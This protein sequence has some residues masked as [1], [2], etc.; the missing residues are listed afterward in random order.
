M[1]IKSILE[2]NKK[3]VKN[4]LLK[5]RQY[6][7]LELP[8]YIDFDGVLNVCQERLGTKTLGEVVDFEKLDG[9]CLR[10]NHNI[11]I[12]KGN[13]RGTRNITLTNPVLYNLL[14]NAIVDNWELL[15]E[16]FAKGQN[17]GVEVSS[18]PVVPENKEKFHNSTAILNW[19][20]LMEQGSLRRSLKYKRMM[21]TD[22][23]HCYENISLEC[24]KNALL[25]VGVVDP[26]KTRKIMARDIENVLGTIEMCNGS[27]GLPQ[28]SVVYDL[29]AELV[30]MNVDAHIV[31][32]LEKL[33]LADKCE[34]LRY[35]DDYRVFSNSMDALYEVRGVL[36]RVLATFGMEL[37]I[38]KTYI[39]EDIVSDALKKDKVYDIENTPIYNGKDWAFKGLT[40]HLYYIKSFGDKFPDSGQLKRLL[41][42]FDDRLTNYNPAMDLGDIK[43]YAGPSI[44]EDVEPMIAIAVHILEQNPTCIPQLSRIIGRLSSLQC[45]DKQLKTNINVCQLLIE[46]ENSNY[47]QV[48]LQKLT[49]HPE[50]KDKVHYDEPLCSCIDNKENVIWDYSFLRKDLCEVQDVD[51]EIVDAEILNEEP[52]IPNEVLLTLG[53]E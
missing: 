4:F 53:Y 14:V 46:A 12:P 21:V 25:H 18:L 38:Q 8:D 43:I 29:L 30:L 11:S 42:E 16:S 23:S 17:E 9:E 2:L 47:A 1:K 44:V 19:W 32:E 20:N 3:E 7:T 31:R 37:N 22:I 49:N 52:M 39:S 34:I 51:V 41:G 50:A 36:K 6:C 10:V 48:W 40:K 5:S 13:G 27:D 28:G 24:V 26:S 33:N 35:R 15:L 45:T